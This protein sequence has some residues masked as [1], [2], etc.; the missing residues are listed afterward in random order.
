MPRYLNVKGKV[1]RAYSPDYYTHVEIVDTGYEYVY[2]VAPLVLTKDETKLLH[3]VMEELA[4]IL[5][6]SELTQAERLESV[7]RKRGLPDKI[8][9]L[10]KSEVVGYSWLEPLMHDENLEDIQCFRAETPVRVT[11]RDFGLIESNIVPSLDEVDRIVRILAHRGGSGIHRSRPILDSVI[12]PTGDRAALTY[13]SEVSP[14]SSFTI[15]KFPRNPWTPT[16]IML[17]GM[18][19]PEAMAFLWLGIEAKLPI[20]IFGEMGSGKSV[21]GDELSLITWKGLPLLMR[22]DEL[23]SFMSRSG[24]YGRLL[25]CSSSGEARTLSLVG[26]S[27]VTG[28]IRHESPDHLVEVTLE[29]GRSIIVTNDHSVTVLDSTDH[30]L[31][32]KR[33][34]ELRPG[35]DRMPVITG[36]KLPSSNLNPG[37]LKELLVNVSKGMCDLDEHL[38]S[39]V[40]SIDF[41]RFIG[42]YLARGSLCGSTITLDDVDND[43]M[44]D[45]KRIC[46]RLGVAFDVKDNSYTIDSK[47][48]SSL[49]LSLG[50]GSSEDAKC[51]PVMYLCMPR[52]WKLALLRAL[53]KIST[54]KSHA[55]LIMNT[56][57]RSLSSGLIYA[58]SELG[59]PIRKKNIH[60]KSGTVNE[61]VIEGDL[62]EDPESVILDMARPYSKVRWTRVVS[63]TRVPSRTRYVYDLEVPLTQTF[64]SGDCV[65]VH[66]TSLAN[67]LGCL[68]RPSASIILVQDVPE[69]KIPH[70]NLI[71]LSE[72]KSFT[73][74][75]VGTVDMETL[76]AHALRRSTDYLIVNEV[77]YGEAKAFA[78]YVATGH[79]GI[80]SFHA[81]NINEVFSRFKSLGVDEATMSSVRILI[82]TIRFPSSKRG[83]PFYLR[84]V[85]AIYYITGLREYTPI[86]DLVFDYDSV[87]DVLV[88]INPGS[89]MEEIAKRLMVST[90]R[91]NEELELRKSFMKSV[92]RA[93]KYGKF[94]SAEEWFSILR[95]YY[96]DPRLALDKLKE[97]L[98]TLSS[99]LEKKSHDKKSR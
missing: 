38:M 74:G 80:T 90:E 87:N 8:I 85:R 13:R 40:L 37:V 78:Q 89:A 29:D 51:L 77:R 15:R 42:Y 59:I 76:V 84:R 56:R 62:L 92:L 68:I 70:E 72:R 30:S 11:H 46:E 35:I 22:F 61:L 79:G 93:A 5:K 66:N 71:S 64:I 63:V 88:E 99:G 21:S 60:L 54:R 10:V 6:P 43:I 97:V 58:F 52:E 96:R 1:V 75:A 17:T 44:I 69:M 53:L 94:L 65:I 39:R 33:T 47:Q 83:A 95:I 27:R 20:L 36:F 7:L 82:H 81:G 31:K 34:E 14:T 50:C 19:T 16:R 18:L 57:S 55:S 32:V 45:I 73:L 12:L 26:L 49:L 9:Y 23:W 91:L 25:G 2:K 4:Y 67:S 86:A 98:S 41:A 3:S 24:T 48:L 28:L